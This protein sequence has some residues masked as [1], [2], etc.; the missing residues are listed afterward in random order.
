MMKMNSEQSEEHREWPL[1]ITLEWEMRS[2]FKPTDWNLRFHNEVIASLRARS[3]FGK[4]FEGSYLTNKVRLDYRP[5]DDRVSFSSLED[6]VEMGIIV[7]LM[8]S[9]ESKICLSNGRKYSIRHEKRGYVFN[10]EEGNDLA[11]TTFNNMTTPMR[12]TFT[13][14]ELPV[15]SEIHPYLIALLSHYYAIKSGSGY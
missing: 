4:S 5:S 10:D 7:R 11:L 13:L 12:S 1:G 14:L 15:K 3:R 8:T 9:H 2:F 6:G